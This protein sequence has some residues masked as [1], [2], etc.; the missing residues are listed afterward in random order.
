MTTVRKAVIPAAGLGTRLLPATKAL[1]KEMLPVIDKPAIQYVIEEASR[2]GIEDILVVTSRGKSTI[3]DHFDRALDL[4]AALR[5]S[6]KDA[7][8]ASISGLSDLARLHYVR[9][10]EALG[11]GHAVAV[12]RSHVGD[13]PFAVLL[14]DDLMV[15]DSTVLA[16]MIAAHDQHQGSVIALKPYPLEEISAYGAADTE[17]IEGEDRLL[18]VRGVVEKPA[19]E[20]APSDLAMM[21]RYVF[22]P[23]IF[24]ALERTGP[25]AGGEIQLTDAVGLLMA[26]QPVFGYVFDS[27]RLDIGKKQDYLRAIVELALDRDDLGADFGAFL[28]DVVKRRG[29]V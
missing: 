25:G 29:L 17:Q 7:Q 20:E 5:A 4:E 28:A 14:P 8:L 15:E 6:G 12:A 19:P 22:T 10:G 26:D 16:G 24:A 3:E 27:G 2:A 1:P 11:L 9:Q 23:E 13:E 18:R 21:G